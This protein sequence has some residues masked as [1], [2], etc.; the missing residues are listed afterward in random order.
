VR[1]PAVTLVLATVLSACADAPSEAPAAIRAPTVEPTV[2]TARLPHARIDGQDFPDKVL[3]LTWDDGPDSNTLELGGYLKSHRISATFFVVGSW[4]EGLS[5]DPGEGK[6][7]FESGYEYLPILGDLVGLGHRLG[8][9]TLHHVHL[10]EAAGAATVDRELR[11]NQQNLDPFLTSELRLFRAPG[12]AWGSFAA[13]IVDN[14]PYLSR[15]T[16]PIAWDIDRKDWDESLNCRDPR[17]ALECER[18]APGFALRMKASVVA[19]RYVSAIES[20]GHG[21]VLLHDR[22]GHVGSRYGLEIAHAL[23]PQLEARGFVFAAPVLRFSPLVV[24]HR[25]A[26][27]SGAQRWD[28]TTVTMGDVNGD[29][30]EDVCG[31]AIVGAGV[32]CAVSVQLTSSSFAARKQDAR[33]PH[34]AFRSLKTPSTGSAPAGQLHLADVTGDRQADVC[35]ASIDGIACAAA[36]VAGVLGAFRSWSHENQSES[37]RL[38]DIDGDGKA[39]ACNRTDVGISCARNSGRLFEPAR[40]WLADRTLASATDVQLA[41]VDGDSRAD[42]CGHVGSRV[43][44]ALSTGKG[45]GRLEEWSSFSELDH[46]DL[47]FGDLNGDGRQ[48][49]CSRTRDGG[50]LCALSTGRRFTKPTTWLA[51]SATAAADGWQLSDVNGDG[52]ADL[53]G[54]GP[55]GIVC[56]LA[57]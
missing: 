7:V 50:V 26:D 27:V 46:G 45:F 16:G 28:E 33:L 38:A 52:R 40:A 22:V 51:A 34:A 43:M 12:G 4:I 1:I 39:D 10:R 57:P 9:H 20:A 23:I 24:R 6:G 30:R 17:A 41:D 54:R 14:D 35:V 11:E 48:D 47:Y 18:G 19:A 37:F 31:R 55:D 32:T 53:C 36:N 21:I 42:V 56:G 15:M 5:D 13:N 25:E 29:G 8:N 49:V 44:C 3:S 2:A